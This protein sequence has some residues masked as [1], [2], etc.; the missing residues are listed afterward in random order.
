M[1]G[2]KT[3]YGVYQTESKR[4]GKCW[5]FSITWYDRNGV[6]NR[7]T[8]A[9]FRTKTEAEKFAQA[10]LDKAWREK[11]GIADPAAKEEIKPVTVGEAV[12]E[13]LKYREDKVDMREKSANPHRRHFK[14]AENKLIEWQNH[15][16]AA[17]EIHTIT[18][19]DLV[20]WIAHEKRRGTVKP[21][22]ISR[23]VNS[24]RA[25]LH[26]IAER[27]EELAN[28]KAPKKPSIPGANVGRSR[29]L[30]EDEIKALA[31]VMAADLDRYRDLYDFFR[32]ALGSASRVDEV[33]SLRWSD[34]DFATQ[35]VTF[36]ASKTQK[37]KSLRLPSVVSILKKRKEEGLGNTTFVF[38]VRDHKL[39]RLLKEVAEQADIPYGKGV[40]RG[41]IIHDLR[42]TALSNLLHA[43]VDP[44]VVSKIYASHHSLQQTNVYLNPT[45]KRAEH[46]EEIADALVDLATAE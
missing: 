17:R 41:I 30:E 14:S 33:L 4:H 3:T 25:C 46:G 35:T 21:N 11:H 44:I 9:G 19:H 13:Y 16:G 40:E 31:G 5:A 45:R 32:V 24:I 15:I 6:R 38:T 27:R 20:S 12:Q 8:K 18:Q 37:L 23:S 39:R 28:W 7:K 43:G 34:I 22:S 2:K 36:F 26:Y 1:S 42:G 10:L 29:P